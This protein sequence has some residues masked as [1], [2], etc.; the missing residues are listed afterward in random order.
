MTTHNA[1]FISKLRQIEELAN[2]V[3]GELPQTLLMLRTRIQHVVVLA[4]TLRGRLE[5][6]SVAIVPVETGVQPPAKP[7]K[8]PA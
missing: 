7:E 4:K 8:P 5:F 3:H 1:D 6:G 2:V